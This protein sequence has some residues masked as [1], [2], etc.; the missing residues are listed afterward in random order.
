MMHQSVISKATRGDLNATF[1]TQNMFRRH[2]GGRL[3]AFAML[4]IACFVAP[5]GFAQSAYPVKPIRIVLGFSAGGGTDVIT[6]AIGRYL[7]ESL[8]ASVVIDNK[9]GA[10]ANIAA[11]IV[12]KAPSDGYTLLYNTS[13]IA[14]S[15]ALYGDKLKYDVLKDLVP[16]GRATSL[17]MVLLVPANSKFGN[18]SELVAY[19]RANS[20]KLDYGSGGNGNVTHLSAL[21]FETAASVKGA[22]IPYKGEGPAIADLMAGHIQFYFATSAG[23]IPAVASGKVRALAVAASSRLETLPLVPTLNETVAKGVEM[24]AWSGMMAP[25]GTPTAIIEKLNKTL[26]AALVDPQVQ[27]FFVAQSAVANP[28]SPSEYSTFLHKEVEALTKVIRDAKVSVDE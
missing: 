1:I 15:P 16:I 20:G 24:S 19:M 10:N 5:L 2:G 6:R 12:A 13:S 18:V 27:A 8:G 9:P 25:I 22:H 14:S 21:A 7:G 4:V 11:E 3:A 26:N 23:A 17:P 28:S